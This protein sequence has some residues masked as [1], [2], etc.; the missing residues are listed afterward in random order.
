MTRTLVAVAHGTRSAAGQAQIRALVEAVAYKRSG[1]DVRLCHVDVQQPRVAATMAGLR[2]A[3]IVPLLLST[4]YHLRVDVAQAAAGARVT[5]PLGP[6]PVLTES[7][8]RRTGHED[9]VVLAAAGS[10]DPQWRADIRKVAAD[11]DAHVGYASGNLPR[12]PDVIA[13][14][15]RRGAER[16][17]I[18]A[19]LLAE[20]VF[21]QSLNRA[22]ATTVTPPLC[23]D[24]VVADLVLRRYDLTFTDNAM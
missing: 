5:P 3:V 10:S 6:D 15:R 20:G 14:L 11:L 1:L 9:A 2:D 13:D 8:A 21:Y 18:A 23:H 16:I 12:V 7:L 19:Y 4:G 24:P 17:T 22:G